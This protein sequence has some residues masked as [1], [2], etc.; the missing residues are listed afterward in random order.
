MQNEP[1]RQKAFVVCVQLSGLC[2]NTSALSD[3][4]ERLYDALNGNRSR[5]IFSRTFQEEG[6]EFVLPGDHFII[7]GNFKADDVLSAVE[8]AASAVSDEWCRRASRPVQRL[9]IIV[10]EASDKEQ[11]V[12]GLNLAS[13]CKPAP[14]SE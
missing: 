12:R 8:K 7:S 14:Q 3:L 10:I 4:N 13:V 11:P 1:T 2:N 5:P 6:E 9:P